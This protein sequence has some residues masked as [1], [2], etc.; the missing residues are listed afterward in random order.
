MPRIKQSCIEAVRAQVNLADVVGAHVQLKRVGNRFLG[1]SPFSNEKTPSFNVHPDKGFYYCFST[2]QGGDVFKFVQTVENLSFYEAVEALCARFNIPLE[3]EEG[4][5]GPAAGQGAS[6]RKELFGIHEAAAAYFHEC[7]LAQKAPA[8]AVRDYWIQRRGFQLDVAAKY[9]IG[10]APPDGGKLAERLLRLDFSAE[11]IAE[12]GLFYE[13][14]GGWGNRGDANPRQLRARFRGRLMIPIRDVQ[15]RVIAFTARQLEG[16]TP[17]DDVPGKYVN[18]PETLLFKKSHVLFGLDR[19]R[20]AIG[21]DDAHFLLVEGQ[22]DAIRCWEHGL[23]TAVAPQGT[24]I[25]AEQLALLTRYSN[26]VDVFLDGDAAGRRAALRALPLA[27]KAGLELRFLPLPEGSDPDALLQSEGADAVQ[28]LRAQPLSAMA[29]CL[30][31][32]LPN[33]IEATPRDKAE[34]LRQIVEVLRECDSVLAAQAN[35]EEAAHLL[36]VER[37]VVENEWSRARSG[38]SR[39]NVNEIPPKSEGFSAGKLTTA[40]SELLFLLI[41]YDHLVPNIAEVLDTDWLANDSPEARLLRSALSRIGEHQW[42]G[43]ESWAQ[44]LEDSAEKQLLYRLLSLERELDDPLDAANRC[45]RSLYA[46]ALD[47]QRRRLEGLILN[48]PNDQPDRLAELFRERKRLRDLAA[49]CPQISPS[50]LIS[51]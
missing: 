40:V 29:L 17:A 12:S 45:L 9:Q 46:Q 5:G 3:Y 25:T 51:N 23:T 10:F 22:L 50:V 44:S 48:T 33:P 49:E 4:S 15:G 34:A 24:A 27:F 31:E 43:G 30:Q 35:L 1:L 28:Q 13:P 19:A 39:G 38:V 20:T 36:R 41:R 2:S 6:R 42:K 7:F 47:G 37:H 8:D 26:R 21:K 32:W 14:R 11:A 18:S 16:I